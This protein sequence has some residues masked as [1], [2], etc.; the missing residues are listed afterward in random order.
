ETVRLALEIVGIDH[1]AVVPAR[2]V[3]AHS[4]RTGLLDPVEVFLL[5]TNDRVMA[6]VRVRAGCYTLIDAEL[7][8]ID[9]INPQRLP[10]TEIPHQLGA[11]EL[12][13]L[14]V[15]HHGGD[16]RLPEELLRPCLRVL[17]ATLD[18]RVIH[19]AKA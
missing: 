12:I 9:E 15:L 16:L 19:N 10:G 1:E 2:V 14:D 13:V 18:F 5:E 11:L 4:R 8:R 3:V 6:M 7:R 17:D